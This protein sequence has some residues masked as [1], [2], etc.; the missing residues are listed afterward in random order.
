MSKFNYLIACAISV[1]LFSCE[2][3]TTEVETT[4]PTKL[5]NPYTV[6]VMQEA[7]NN[8][9]DNYSDGRLENLE[10]A[11]SHYYVR[12]LPEDET[13][14]EQLYNLP[15]L[16]FYP[17]PLDYD[18]SVVGPDKYV[19]QSVGTGQIPWQYTVIPVGKEFPLATHEIIDELFLPFE[20]AHATATNGRGAIQENDCLADALQGE[21]MFITGNGEGGPYE[22]DCDTSGGGSTGGGSSGTCR[23]CPKGQILVEN[24]HTGQIE[25]FGRKYD[26]VPKVKVR[27]RKWF[28]TKYDYTDTNGNFLIAHEFGGDGEV[29]YSILYTNDYGYIKPTTIGA[30]PATVNGPKMKGH[31]EYRSTRGSKS[32]L[33]GA[34]MRGLYDYHEIYAPM[35]GIDRPPTG[36]KFKACENTDCGLATMLHSN[37][38]TTLPFGYKTLGKWL[39]SDIRVG[40]KTSTYREIYKTTIHE[41]GHAAHWKVN[42]DWTFSSNWRTLWAP[43]HMREAWATGIADA[44]YKEKFGVPYY[45][46]C[47]GQENAR[48]ADMKNDGYP[49]VF[50]RD[51]IDDDNDFDPNNEHC[52]LNDEVEGFTVGEIFEA[53]KR[54]H[55]A[56]N[57][58]AMNQWRDKLIE[59]R[60]A[61]RDDLIDYFRQ[62]ED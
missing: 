59:I 23:N 31:W 57:N 44:V 11:A 48:L 21:A 12:F 53:L 8:I 36:I 32:Y 43:R 28:K 40:E 9:K 22:E 14:L 54:V 45:G 19:D 61:E 55:A 51:L 3:D 26:G 60:P 5:R 49:R 39:F 29:N 4:Q 10:I 2:L 17:Y 30:G 56:N 46:T 38:T 52:D 42:G 41:L 50:V 7:W 15:D 6:E 33:W 27:A 24:T 18:Y 34:I 58:N 37:A 20:L 25:R 13:Q 35:Y 62:W 16:E 1:L 47:V